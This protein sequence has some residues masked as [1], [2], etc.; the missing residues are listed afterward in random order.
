MNYNSPIVNNMIGA[1]GMVYSQG[2]IPPNPI[3][4]V[5]IGATGYNNNGYGSMNG[6]YNGNYNGYYNP[7]LELQ[8]QRLYQQQIREQQL[9]EANMMKSIMKT[10]FKSD[11]E[12]MSEEDV[13]KRLSRFDPQF[14]Q[15]KNVDVELETMARLQNVHDNAYVDFNPYTYAQMV[16]HNRMFDEAK[17]IAPDSMG[18]YEFGNVA[19]YIYVNNK[20]Q[21]A[22][23][24]S[25]KLNKLYD[26]NKYNELI[27]MH[28]SSS[29]YMNGLK[30]ISI[31][32][33]ETKLPNIS[34][35]YQIR[36]KKFFDS[37]MK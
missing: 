32:D 16:E 12:S 10:A 28:S 2:N 17:Q 22:K 7:Y 6:Y 36:R 29:G 26:S 9:K 20:I 19:G 13:E 35:E 34:S 33:M 1:N 25:R 15:Q 4:N 11:F 21:E 18:L 14:E 3:G 23:R 5:T 37:I 24:E 31:D 27:N 8:R 30:N